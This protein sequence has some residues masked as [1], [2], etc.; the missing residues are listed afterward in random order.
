MHPRIQEVLEYLDT[1]RAD[2]AKA[3][4]AVS[5]AHRGQRP[6][7]DR[8]SVAEV[9]EHLAIV[10]S[11][12][13]QLANGR[14]AAAKA[15]GLGPE[16]ETS[17][18]IDSINRARITDRSQRVTAPAMIQPQSGTDAASVWSALQQARANLREA[19]LAGD[20]LALTEI[21]HQHPA[22]GLIN[23]Y[24]WLVFVGSHEARHTA[25]IREIASELTAHSIAATDAP[26]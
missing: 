3:V 18:I 14:I 5:P 9:L 12:V 26:Q 20:G 17:P 23:L 7:P 25:Q 13:V 21:S 11:R 2:L 10:E 6:G 24:Q 19:V 15:A 16:L 1:T 8:W 22:L 4:E